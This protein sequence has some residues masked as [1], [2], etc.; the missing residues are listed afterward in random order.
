MYLVTIKDIACEAGVSCMTVSNVIHGNSQHVSPAT[1]QRVRQ[2]MQRLQYVPNMS[3][4]GLVSNSSR[5]IAFA[6]GHDDAAVR[7]VLE[8]PFASAVVGSVEQEVRAQNYFL[9]FSG[10]QDS[11]NLV[12]T[13]HSWNVDGVLMFGLPDNTAQELQHGL[14]R[15]LVFIDGYFPQNTEE[16]KNVGIDDRTAAGCLTQYLIAHGHRHIG[17][18]SAGLP[19][20]CAGADRERMHGW[21]DALRQAGTEPSQD[22]LLPCAG[23]SDFARIYRRLQEFT[24][25]FVC[26][27]LLAARLQ[28]YLQDRG[29][30]VPQDISITGFDG[31]EY[32]EMAR[33]KITTMRQDVRE[34]GRRAVRQLLEYIETGDVKQPCIRL[35]CTLV[36]QESVRDVNA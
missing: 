8:D 33:P 21:A 17:F 4:R 25:L 28:L 12:Q 5:L 3:A 20:H 27:D 2:V 13:I 19:A 30:R 23:E 16:Y 6:Y 35:P 11:G 34:K 10:V 9:L 7:T 32:A 14:C 1:V 26:S 36:E 22:W 29:V 24:A 15:P 31:N 18:C